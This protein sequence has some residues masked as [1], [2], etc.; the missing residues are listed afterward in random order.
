MIRR[1]PRSTLFPYTTLFRSQTRDTRQLPA[2]RHPRARQIRPRNLLQR[3]FPA[4]LLLQLVRKPRLRYRPNVRKRR[5]IQNLRRNDLERLLQLRHRFVETRPLYN[6][7]RLAQVTRPHLPL[8]PHHLEYHV[9]II[10]KHRL[11]HSTRDPKQRIEERHQPR[12]DKSRTPAQY[13][14]IKTLPAPHHVVLDRPR[15]PALRI[16]LHIARHVR[17]ATTTN[18]DVQRWPRP[19]RVSQRFAKSDVFDE[20]LGAVNVFDAVLWI[21]SPHAVAMDLDFFRQHGPIL[22][23]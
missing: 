18:R 14:S 7:A 2:H 19:A 17:V 10:R 21:A 15:E 11:L 16:L 23:N 22:S 5:L 12:R 20:A 3:R 6:P 13:F 4:H 8:T 9:R 1:P